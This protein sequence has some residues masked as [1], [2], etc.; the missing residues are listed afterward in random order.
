MHHFFLVFLITV[1]FLELPATKAYVAREQLNTDDGYCDS[2][3][4]GRV[5][6][7]ESDF[8]DE[9]CERYDCSEGFLNIIGHIV[10]FICNPY[11]SMKKLEFTL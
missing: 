7:G 6:I 10:S 5:P 1:F 8:N 11:F 4:Y 3:T 9:R 2:C